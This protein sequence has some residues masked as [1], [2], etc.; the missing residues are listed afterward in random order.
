MTG[1]LLGTPIIGPIMSSSQTSLISGAY[2]R[3]KCEECKTVEQILEDIHD[4]IN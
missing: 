2:S 3:C 1:L 4:V